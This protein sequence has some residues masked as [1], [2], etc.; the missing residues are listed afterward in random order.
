VCGIR[1]D[2]EILRLNF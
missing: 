2:Q 1:F